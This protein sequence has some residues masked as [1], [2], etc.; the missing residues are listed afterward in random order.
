VQKVVTETNRY[1]EQL[2]NSGGDIF[3]ERSSENKWQSVTAEEIYVV[4]VTFMLMGIEN[5]QSDTVAL[6]KSTC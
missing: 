4:L 5:P 3:C 2:E 6:T 1:A